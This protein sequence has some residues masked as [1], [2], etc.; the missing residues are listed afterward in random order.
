MIGPPVA[1]T[2]HDVTPTKSV[3]FDCT[4]SE[5]RSQ[6]DAMTRAGR[7]FVSVDRVAEALEGGR[8]LPRGA[9]CLTFADNYR[10]FYTHAWPLLKKRRIPV[11]QFVHTGYVGSPVGRPK[12]T[13][14]QLRELDRS[15]LVTIG[16]QT[17]SHPA[18]LR[19]LSDAAVRRE[20]SA[21]RARLEKEL[22][23]PVR[24]LA[25]PNGKFDGRVARL[26]RASGYRLAFTERLS[27]L[28]SVPSRWEV[29]R[30][31]HTK[32]RQA[33]RSADGVEYR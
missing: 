28:T 7:V 18:D 33:I 26:A 16:S 6:I 15:G 29:P 1:L 5:F 22:G 3:W 10:G 24:Y 12:M 4:P 32:W 17:V 19:S 13:W 25:Y 14:S 23:H 9:V 31:V 8:P 21:S 2:Y 27:F 30:W 20:F 11:A